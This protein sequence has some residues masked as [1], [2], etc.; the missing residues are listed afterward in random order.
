VP[1]MIGKDRLS[2]AKTADNTQPP[3]SSAGL[4]AGV[5]HRTNLVNRPP[6]PT[7][8][9]CRA[10]VSNTSRDSPFLIKP[11][12]RGFSPYRNIERPPGSITFRASVH[13]RR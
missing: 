9:R 10:G 6:H 2:Y 11:H 13:S 4:D 5:R 12:D 3:A 7:V 8:P 1:S